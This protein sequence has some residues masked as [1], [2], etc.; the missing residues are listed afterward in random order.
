M[1]KLLALGVVFG[2]AACGGDDA[3]TD[4]FETDME[5]QQPAPAP[6]PADTM[7]MD[8]MMQDTMNMGEDTMNMDM[9]EGTG[10]GM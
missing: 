8:T 6:M 9:E 10:T 5:L 3:G 4:D 7:P 2:L 1:K